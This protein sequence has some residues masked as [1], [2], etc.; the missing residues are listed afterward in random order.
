MF[1]S[2]IKLFR[3]YAGLITVTYTVVGIMYILFS[4]YILTML[5]NEMY[6][7]VSIAHS[8]KGIMFILITASLLYFLIKHYETKLKE[9]IRILEKRNDQLNLY[10]FHLSHNIRKPVANLMGL[11]ELIHMKAN[12]FEELN[13]RIRSCLVELDGL[14][15]EA[16]DNLV[17]NE[18]D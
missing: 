1:S 6:S 13:E 15:R 14:L 7:S 9:N 2:K 16:N 11:H 17:T 12:S 5:F 8:F 3:S 10:A 4:D 18:N